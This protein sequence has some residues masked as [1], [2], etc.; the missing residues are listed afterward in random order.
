MRLR[1]PQN[2]NAATTT[3]SVGEIQGER[4]AEPPDCGMQLGEAQRA[5]RKRAM[6]KLHDG[7]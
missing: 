4:D 7:I 3:M 1:T 6:S 2:V 5:M